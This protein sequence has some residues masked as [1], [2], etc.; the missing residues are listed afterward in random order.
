MAKVYE[1]RTE[2]AEAPFLSGEFWEKGTEVRGIVERQY[3]TENG[4]CYV[5][6]LERPVKINGI[7]DEVS[8][9]SMGNLSGFTMAL[10]A[11]RTGLRIG[12]VI[13]LECTGHK[14]PKQEG[15]S[16]RPNFA[17]KIVRP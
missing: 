7:E 16:P 5:L 13:E 6:E 4:I 9:V 12:D 14:P 3:P 17:I 8:T 2:D 15:Y 10:Q 11:A 1:G